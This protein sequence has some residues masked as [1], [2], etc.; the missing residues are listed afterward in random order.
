[1]LSQGSRIDRRRALRRCRE[2]FGQVRQLGMFLSIFT[3][4]YT[5]IL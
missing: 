2:A 1:M 5:I 3:Q 4:E